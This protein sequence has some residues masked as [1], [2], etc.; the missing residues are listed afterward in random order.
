MRTLARCISLARIGISR[1][2]D[3]PDEGRIHEARRMMSEPIKC[4]CPRCFC[5]IPASQGT[6]RDGKLYCSETCAYE[7]TEQTCVC[8]HERCEHREQAS[9]SN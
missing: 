5:P 7:C 2:T 8:V 6:L 1:L 9:K 4:A 3:A